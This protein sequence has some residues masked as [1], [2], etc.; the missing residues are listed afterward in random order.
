MLA[1]KLFHRVAFA[2]VNVR[3]PYVAVRVR[4]TVNEMVDSDRSERVGLYMHSRP[5]KYS[6]AWWW[7]ARKVCD[8]ML[9]CIRW[10]TAAS[11]APSER[12]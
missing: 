9:Y 8:R 5:L 11:V 3:S 1:G 2:L 10:W 12:G 6:S 4:G 7:I